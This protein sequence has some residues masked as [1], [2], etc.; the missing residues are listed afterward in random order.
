MELCCEELLHEGEKQVLIMGVSKA[1][2]VGEKK[3]WYP[4]QLKG[5][6][7]PLDLAGFK[8]ETT[9]VH[10]LLFPVL[11]GYTELWNDSPNT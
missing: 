7:W 2:C 4:I 6:I 1:F 8:V 5:V 9:E 3:C 10:L 11:N